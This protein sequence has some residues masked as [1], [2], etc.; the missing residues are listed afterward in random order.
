[1]G[2]KDSDHQLEEKKGRKQIEEDIARVEEMKNSDHPDQGKERGQ[3]R[4]IDTNLEE[5]EVPVPT[6]YFAIN[7]MNLI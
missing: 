1:M 5:K 3:L 2:N 6:E 4:I 7:L